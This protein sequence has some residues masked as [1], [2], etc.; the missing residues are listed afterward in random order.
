MD[1]FLLKLLREGQRQLR[2]AAREGTVQFR[3]PGG[4][5]VLRH[6][7]LVL[8][9]GP[10]VDARGVEPARLHHR[11][12]ESRHQELLHDQLHRIGRVRPGLQGIHRRQAAAGAQGAAGGG[13]VPGLGRPAGPQGVAGERTS[14]MAFGPL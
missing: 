10:V 2:N 5:V 11:G 8:A 6:K 13:E 1:V 14:A 3:F 12:A 7:Q 9:G 4:V